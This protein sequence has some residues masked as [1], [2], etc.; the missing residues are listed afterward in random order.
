MFDRVDN[1]EEDCE[2][3][4]DMRE[5]IKEVDSVRECIERAEKLLQVCLYIIIKA[6]NLGKWYTYI[7]V[8]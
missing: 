3:K 1:T 7:F 2:V 4:P 8:S 6:S 5:E